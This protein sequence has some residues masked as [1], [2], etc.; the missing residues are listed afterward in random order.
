MSGTGNNSYEGYEVLKAWHAR[1]FGNIGP[2]LGGAYATLLRR[3]V[4]PLPAMAIDM[5][6][7]NGEMLGCLRKLGI[8]NVQGIELNRV[9][10]ERAEHAGYPSFESLSEWRANA[11]GGRIDLLT[12]MHVFE[13]IPFQILTSLFRDL[14]QDLSLNGRIIAAFPNGDSPFSATAFHSDPTHLTWLTRQ[15]CET[16]AHG[17]QL[18][19]LTYEAFPSPGDHAPNAIMRGRSRLRG[20]VERLVSRCL[21]QIYYGGQRVELAPVAVAVWGR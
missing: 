7:G 10:R 20:K 6:F 5:G 13:H 2:E 21:S 19:L 11:K 8:S 12:A 9:L 16:L 15:K 17:T 18:K 4:S 14:E 1:D 3:H